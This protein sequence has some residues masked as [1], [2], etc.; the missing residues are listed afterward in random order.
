MA[1]VEAQRP[2][3]RYRYG[4]DQSPVRGHMARMGSQVE[5]RTG[6]G[7]RKA[8]REGR[9]QGGGKRAGC[10]VNVW[11]RVGKQPELAFGDDSCGG[12]QAP[13]MQS[14]LLAVFL[15]LRIPI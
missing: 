14:E 1:H 15:S 8:E 3:Q 7:V 4:A 12:L 11:I 6:A 13:R 5:L 2:T 10:D 9:G